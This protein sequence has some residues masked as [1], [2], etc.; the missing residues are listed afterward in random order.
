[1]KIKV[2]VRN[3]CLKCC[4]WVKYTVINFLCIFGMHN[5][6]INNVGFGKMFFVFRI[7]LD[8]PDL[9]LTLQTTVS[10]ANEIEIY[11]NRKNSPL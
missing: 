1:M 4:K 9:L 5:E 8:Q 11:A 2:F 6:Y 3:R 7:D 10:A